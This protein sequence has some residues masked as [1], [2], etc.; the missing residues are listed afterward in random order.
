[1][2]EHY[3]FKEPLIKIQCNNFDLTKKFYFYSKNL[4]TLKEETNN[5]SWFLWVQS[6]NKQLD[7]ILNFVYEIMTHEN[8]LRELHYE[9]EDKLKLTVSSK[10]QVGLSDLE[11]VVIV[12][13]NNKKLRSI[14]YKEILDCRNFIERLS[15]E[16]YISSGLHTEDEIKTKYRSKR[17][18]IQMISFLDAFP[19]K[20]ANYVKNLSFILECIDQKLMKLKLLYQ[21]LNYDRS[22]DETT[23]KNIPL[24]ESFNKFVVLKFFIEN[25]FVIL[26]ENI[27]QFIIHSIQTEQNVF[28]SRQIFIKHL[29]NLMIHDKRI[30][31]ENLILKSEN[32]K[33][34][35]FCKRLR[36]YKEMNRQLMS[37][38][39]K[40]T[41]LEIS[42]IF[43][44][45]EEFKNGFLSYN[46][47]CIEY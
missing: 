39:Y 18:Q 45:F 31:D 26:K 25:D 16:Y 35:D 23:E 4:K 37:E 10:K 3:H 43:S 14:L 44:T 47:K 8:K 13:N 36:M 32:I 42:E 41:L 24:I 28:V 40:G 21:L 34:I 38:D 1:M 12:F 46:I 5:S 7:H 19:D 9:L 2:S 11:I 15:L 17:I 27:N 20:K 22:F 30:Q 33:L 29:E 6:T